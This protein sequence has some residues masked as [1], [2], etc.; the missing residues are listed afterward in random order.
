VIFVIKRN[1][2]ALAKL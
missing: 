2:L 1:Q